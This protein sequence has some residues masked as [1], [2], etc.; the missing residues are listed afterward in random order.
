ATLHP[1]TDAL[2]DGQRR[3]TPGRSHTLGPHPEQGRL[4]A[5]VARDHHPGLC[6]PGLGAMPQ[7][8]PLWAE[9]SEVPDLPGDHQRARAA[10]TLP[11]GGCPAPRGHSHGG[12]A[13]RLGA[14]LYNRIQ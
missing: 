7:T 2:I 10:G 11:E 9:T 13:R 3:I 5:G 12:W 1:G 8:T 6:T 4:L 14:I